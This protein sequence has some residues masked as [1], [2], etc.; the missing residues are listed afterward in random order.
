MSKIQKYTCLNQNCPTGEMLVGLGFRCWMAG[1]TNCEFNSWKT[2]WD[3][4]S[5]EL[6]VI[7]ARTTIKE[8][9]SWVQSIRTNTRR[10][11]S[12]EPLETNDFNTDEKAAI[13]V[14]AACQNNTCPALAACVEALIGEGETE[15]VIAASH[16]LANELIYNNIYLNSA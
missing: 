6:G 9:S 12:V 2:G 8:L 1:Y 13:A 10:D 15:P 14:I 5:N 11:I 3:I 4:Y 7:G 16:Q